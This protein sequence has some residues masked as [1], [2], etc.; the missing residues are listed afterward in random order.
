MGE[1]MA[2]VKAVFEAIQPPG[3]DPML[4]F[5]ERDLLLGST[6]TVATLARTLISNS[7]AAVDK[8]F[9]G[10]FLNPPVAKVIRT[11]KTGLT[12]ASTCIAAAHEDFDVAT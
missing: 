12:P 1:L 3:V 10:S 8:P 5:D 7:G 6:Q 4:D 2:K 11:T 9:R